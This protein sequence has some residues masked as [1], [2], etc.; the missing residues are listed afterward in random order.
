MYTFIFVIVCISFAGSVLL[1]IVLKRNY[2]TAVALFFT[3]I[4]DIFL[5]LTD[6]HLALGLVFFSTA[7]IL[8]GARIFLN[9][10]NKESSNGVTG[11]LKSKSTFN[12]LILQVTLRLTTA[13]AV[14][15]AVSIA[16]GG[17]DWVLIMASFYG[18]NFLYN[19]IFAL[20]NFKN[21]MLIAIGLL[22][23]AVCDIMVLTLNLP[24]YTDITINYT[25]VFTVMWIFYIPSQIII[26]LSTAEKRTRP[27][28]V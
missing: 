18:V 10:R 16:N 4:A 27:H 8:Y 19:I 21:D 5:L 12:A 14:M 3:V 6:T 2:T 1:A 7:Q 28:I 15:T 26:G 24:Q 17:F 22:M 13:A 25:L 9:G 23:F 20:R 11:D